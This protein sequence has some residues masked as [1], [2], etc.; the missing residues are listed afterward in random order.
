[1][2]IYK[3]FNHLFHYQPYGLEKL[4]SVTKQW[5]LL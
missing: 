4:A 5:I 1:L 2:F 3:M